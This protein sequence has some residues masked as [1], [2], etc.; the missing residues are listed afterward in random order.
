[1]SSLQSLIL[2]QGSEIFAGDENWTGVCTSHLFCGGRPAVYYIRQNGRQIEINDHA[3]NLRM[4]EWSLPD[5]DKAM[6]TM[7]RLIKLSGD[8]V[9]F[10][11]GVLKTMSPIEDAG[12]AIGKYL[13]VLSKL[14]TY[15]PNT[16]KQ[17]DTQEMLDMIYQFLKLRHA[18]KLALDAK[19]F[20]QS[21]QS[22]RFNFQVGN[23]LID[24]A[25]PSSDKT[26][27]LLRK[28]FDVKNLDDDATFQIILDDR[29][30]MDSY[31]K[32]GEIL[33]VIASITPA[34]AIVSA[35]S[36]IH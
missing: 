10:E 18:D 9:T 22:H 20:G 6:K 14:T 13:D 24:Y 29:Q 36:L 4:F 34:S 1:M 28:M 35:S 15:A 25:K 32:E 23:K 21:K 26:G 30:S 12:L 7:D 8:A 2:S 31:K 27:T 3:L 16:V 11:K 19:V 5:P 33:S 17:Q